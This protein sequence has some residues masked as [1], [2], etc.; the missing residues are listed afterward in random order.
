MRTIAQLGGYTVQQ[1]V[2]TKSQTYKKLKPDLDGMDEKEIMGFIHENPSAMLRPILMDER[3]LVIGF[4]EDEY[5]E[6]LRKKN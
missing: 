6:L 5:E 3:H 1:L 4:K 2:N